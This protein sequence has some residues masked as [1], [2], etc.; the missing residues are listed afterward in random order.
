MALHAQPAA[1]LSL[2]PQAAD[3]HLEQPVCRSYAESSVFVTKTKG[4]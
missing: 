4:K 2:L 3:A 1:Q